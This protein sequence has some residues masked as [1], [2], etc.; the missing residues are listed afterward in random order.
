MLNGEPCIRDIKERLA[1]CASHTILLSSHGS[2]TSRSNL[3]RTGYLPS[4]LVRGNSAGIFPY[5]ASLRD[6]VQMRSQSR[7]SLSACTILPPLVALLGMSL[8]PMSEFVV[9]LLGLPLLP[10][11][12]FLVGGGRGL[13]NKRHAGQDT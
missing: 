3:A 6:S 13:Q 2:C 10:T 7:Q 9:A 1:I 8:L 5:P 12:Q 11:S 4:P